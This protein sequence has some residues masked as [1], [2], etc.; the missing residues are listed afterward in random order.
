[1]RRVGWEGS[2]TAG[3]LHFATILLLYWPSLYSSFL[4][5]YPVL[6]LLYTIVAQPDLLVSQGDTCAT[7]L[8]Y[9]PTA[10]LES[11]L[12]ALLVE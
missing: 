8:S 3:A 7:A 12:P 5:H 2:G 4:P 1:M 10:A 11:R 6:V 9:C